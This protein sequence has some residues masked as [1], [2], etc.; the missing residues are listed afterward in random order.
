[1]ASIRVLVID[2]QM[3][4]DSLVKEVLATFNTEIDVV[5]VST[6]ENA[7]EEIR[8]R[9][10]DLLVVKK[11][12]EEIDVLALMNSAIGSIP[13]IKTVLILEA[14]DSHQ[15]QDYIKAGVNV[16]F[17]EPVEY[18]NFLTSIGHY[19]GFLET[20]ITGQNTGPNENHRWDLS[21]KLTELK[22]QLGAISSILLDEKGIVLARSGDLP[23]VWIES[24]LFPPLMA[25]FNISNK[26]GNFL[27][28]LPP[29]D[30][31]FF[32]GEKYDL[33]LTHINNKIAL[34][35]ILNSIGVEGNFSNILTTVQGGRNE[36]SEIFLHLGVTMEPEEDLSDEKVD[37]LEALLQAEAPII[38]AIFQEVETAVPEAEEVDA[39]WGVIADQEM[40]DDVQSDDVMTYEQAVRLGFAPKE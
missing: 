2:K 8:V 20:K 19:L 39:Y 34:L 15:E 22:Q 14:E 17:T 6:V 26:V 23:D 7:L 29:R 1:M 37:E 27:Q 28:V 40:I 12:S 9:N 31:A 21:G 4:T 38:D 10:F 36:I 35:V 18:S 13:N 33:I 11:A 16:V 32:S 5:S 30:F 25:T 3:E 24:S